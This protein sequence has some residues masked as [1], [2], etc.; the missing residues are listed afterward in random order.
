MG[1]NGSRARSAPA[2]RSVQYGRVRDDGEEERRAG[3]FVSPDIFSRL[4]SGETQG[5]SL[6]VRNI[7][8]AARNCAPCSPMTSQIPASGVR[9]GET[10]GRPRRGAGG[11]SCAA[12]MAMR[13][14]DYERRDNAL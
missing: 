12:S 7:D 1:D 8:S 6:Q 11:K 10:R 3:G 4:P 9:R 13:G 14:R 5:R 2:L